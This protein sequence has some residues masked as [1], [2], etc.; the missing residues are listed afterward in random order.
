MPKLDAL[1]YPFKI[2]NAPGEV[3]ML[4]EGFT[5]FRQI[6]TDGR[7]LPT[8]PQPSW[9]GYSVGKWDG[10]TFVVDTIGV[11]ASTWIDNAGRPHSDALHLTE[12]FQRH[13][14]GHMDILLTI[15]D[16]KTYT[17]PWTVK[18]DLRFLPDTE[19]LEYICGENNKDYEHLTGK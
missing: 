1:P 14:F 3:V 19:L 13:D 6:Y 2:V 5:T 16:P 12:R 10:D 11:N 17:K 9:L 7:A 15:D 4:F 18:E 8:D